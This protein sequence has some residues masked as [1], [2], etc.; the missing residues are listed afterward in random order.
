MKFI[1]KN[2]RIAKRIAQ[3]GYCS[4][5]EAETLIKNGKVK[6][7]GAK[8]L[9]CNVNVSSNDIIHINEKLIIK[10][11]RIRIWLYHKKKGFL[12]TNKDNMGRPNIFDEIKQKVKCRTISVGRLDFNSEGLIL[13]TNNGNLARQL[14]LPKNNIERTYKVRFYGNLD[15]KITQT[16]QKGI[17]INGQKYKPIKVEMNEQKNK[18]VWAKLTLR[19]GK[20][21]EIRKIM[22]YFG[23]TVNRLIRIS[24]GSFV[25]KDLKPGEIN[26]LKT[27]T[28][29]KILDKMNIKCE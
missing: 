29:N 27:D 10:K 9:K 14:E 16:L 12:V 21:R 1:F 15:Y 24:F 19:E 11:N 22:A 20:N 18:N 2:E 3:S 26:E 28:I 4:R 8:I 17:S 23:C 6:L 13:L 5:R 7:N 25:L